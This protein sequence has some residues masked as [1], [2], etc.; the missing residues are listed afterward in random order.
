M[1]ATLS[2]QRSIGFRLPLK[3]PASSS[4]TGTTLAAQ[5][6]EREYEWPVLINAG[7]V[8]IEQTEES[9][10]RVRLAEGETDASQPD[11]VPS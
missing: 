2:G 8:F 4:S 1:V 10:P 9:G 3:M 6:F 5:A 11:G 7:V